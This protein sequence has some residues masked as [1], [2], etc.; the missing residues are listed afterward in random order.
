MATRKFI[1][2]DN[3]LA[4]AYYRYSSHAQNEASIDQQRAEAEKFA[5]ARSLKI[6]Q[7]YADAAISGTTDDRP[8]FQRMLS[9]VKQIKPSA[10][11][12]WKTDR[13][14]RNRI[15]SVIAKKTVRD[16]GCKI[17]Y[18]AEPNA[19]DS[20]EAQLLEG[21]L[22][23]FAEYYSKQLRRN[24]V[25]GQVSN[26]QKGL[27]T[28][29]KTLGYKSESGKEK[30]KRI[31]LDPD[32]AALVQ[33]IFREYADGTPMQVICDELNLQGFRS[34]RGGRFTINSIRS[35][36]LNRAYLGESWYGDQVFK[37]AIPRII[38]DD[39]FERA[40]A[41]LAENKRTASQSVVRDEEAPRYWLSGKLI[42]GHCGA[43]M[44]GMSARSKTGDYHYYYACAN[45]RKHKC[46]KRAVRKSVIEKTVIDYMLSLLY[47]TEVVTSLVVDL[48]ARIKDGQSN[49]TAR[50]SSLKK[51]LK[52]T[53]KQINN[54]LEALKSGVVS[55]TVVQAMNELE[56]RKAVLLD[57]I[58]AEEMRVKLAKTVTPQMLQD[59][60]E[61]FYKAKEL[62][63]TEVRDYILENYIEKIVL[64][65]DKLVIVSSIENEA[66]EIDLS[67]V[68][69]V[70]SDS[71]NEE[72]SSHASRH[73]PPNKKAPC[74]CLFVWCYSK[75]TG[76]EA[77]LRK[78]AGGSFL[79]VTEEFCEAYRKKSAAMLRK[80][81]EESRMLQ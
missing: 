13:I 43:F 12:V 54:L 20:P 5:E 19:D 76:L 30:G 81:Q 57:E 11:I 71:L 33:R 51:A 47:D 22:E 32:G 24:I 4:I 37:D 27:S 16:A 38:S 40:H 70:V 42:C 3:N 29:R 56:E 41:K 59:F 80:I 10:L 69:G 35:I 39:L 58:D 14:A 31:M 25:R 36:L 61:Q 66:K 68:D 62:D 28:G 2:N 45:Q 63:D 23:D 21:L 50:L 9:E 55:Q 72:V 74:R 15:D 79:A 78:R 7:E 46:K 26:A 53:E 8:E 48:T 49:N 67:D 77:A 18:V 65:D 75:S 64:Y 17:L 34:I 44:T 60:F 73:A 1:Q 6:V 52:E